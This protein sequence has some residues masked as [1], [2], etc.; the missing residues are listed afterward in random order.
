MIIHKIKAEKIQEEIKMSFNLD[1]IKGISNLD[2]L[3]FQ[4]EKNERYQNEK[5]E[6]Q[7]PGAL[8]VGAGL[9]KQ[10]ILEEMNMKIVPVSKMHPAKENEGISMSEIEELADNI[11]DVG[12]LNP[13]IVK[14][15][16]NGTYKIVAGERRWTACQLLIREKRWPEDKKI[17]C[18]IFDPDLIKL[19]LTS[20]DK[21]EYVRL[22]ENA[23]QRNRTDADIL[24]ATRKFKVLYDK[25]RAKGEL[26]GVK[27]RDLLANDLKVSKSVVAQFTKLENRGSEEL[28]KAVLDNKVS[29]NAAVKAA[30]MTSEEQ[31]DFVA[32]IPENKK[33]TPQDVDKYNLQ[34]KIV[35]NVETETKNEEQEDV[36]I[37]TKQI[38]R[39]DT[40]SILK[41]IG[42]E[43]VKLNDQEYIRYSKAIKMVEELI[44]KVM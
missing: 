41:M 11:Y 39:Q 36:H 25:L 40:K 7:Q 38:F 18:S 19:N 22:S 24:R 30:D 31:K 15:E 6:T 26:K 16:E 10:N 21:E 43:E 44:K 12:V 34:K 17:R 4:D 2:N 9:V 32:S 37:I 1:K 8:R 33:V 27:T 5:S 28:I 35:K 42:N 13:P 29:I 14:E 23:E 3:K 20:E